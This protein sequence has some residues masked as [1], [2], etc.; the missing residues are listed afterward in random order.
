MVTVVVHPPLPPPRWLPSIVLVH[1]VQHQLIVDVSSSVANSRP[2][3]FRKSTSAQDEKLYLYPLGRI[4]TH[5]PD[6]H[7]ARG[8]NLIRHWDSEWYRAGRLGGLV[9][10]QSNTTTSNTSVGPWVKQPP[11]WDLLAL[12][13]CRNRQKLINWLL[14][15][16]SSVGRYKSARIGEREET[17]STRDEN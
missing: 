5:E 4:Q 7:K 8:Y 11:F 16:P 17:L 13:V 9:G 15:L 3:A 2:R 10:L 1:R 14:K 6:L 12:F